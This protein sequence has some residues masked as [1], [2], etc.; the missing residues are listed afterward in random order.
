MPC[1]TPLRIFSHVSCYNKKCDMN[2][3]VSSTES[4]RYFP[5]LFVYSTEKNM[6]VK[7]LATIAQR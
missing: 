7:P 4:P 3:N 5:G 1:A 6:K 2:C